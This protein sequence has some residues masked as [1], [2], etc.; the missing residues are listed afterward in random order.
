[1]TEQELTQL[2]IKKFGKVKRAAK[3]QL[4]IC[5]P[6]CSSKSNSKKMKRYVSM[7]TLRSWCYICGLDLSGQTL[8]GGEY[9]PVADSLRF[10]VE[11]RKENPMARKL[12]G[13]KF[14]P[15]NK[16]PT[17]HP[18]ICFLFKDWLY[19]LE[20]YYR[21]YGVVY[22]PSDCGQVFGSHP[23][24]SSGDRIIFP[25]I[26]KGKMVGWQMRSIPGT[27]YGD[28]EDVVKYYH[29]FS[30]GDYLYNYDNAKKQPLVVLVEGVKKALK[31]PYAV[32]SW[33]KNISPNQV[34]LLYGW[35]NIVVMLDSELEAQHIGESLALTFR[36]A[37]KNAININLKNH[38]FPSPDEATTEQLETIILT[39]W[40][41]ICR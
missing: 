29:L 26:F 10:E 1:M 33:G 25:T 15:I 34:Q 40:K 16:L 38:G 22:C 2:L 24:I 8:L 39:E 13:S 28:R 20:K 17:T 23:F 6:T 35:Q 36:Q 3:N 21:D 11:D 14:I 41:K 27:T 37:G 5:C 7:T 32:A 31:L 19:D 9:S 18:A 12:P 4:R 30:K